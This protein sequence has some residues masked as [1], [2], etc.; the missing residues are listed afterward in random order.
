MPMEQTCQPD[1]GVGVHV[2]DVIIQILRNAGLSLVSSV[3]SWNTH[4][5]DRVE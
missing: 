4:S 2:R 5:S 3:T 1:R